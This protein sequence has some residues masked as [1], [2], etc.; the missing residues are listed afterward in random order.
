LTNTARFAVAFAILALASGC[1]PRVLVQ[2][3]SFEPKRV[4]YIYF[5][6]QQPGKDSRLYRCEI[7]PDNRVDCAV[8][9][10]LD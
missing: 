5:V 9:F 3:S 10:D 7:L 8:Q 2:P 1:G 6:E 4:N